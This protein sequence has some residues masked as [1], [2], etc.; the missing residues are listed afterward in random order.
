MAPVVAPAAP[1]VAVPSQPSAQPAVVRR[2]VTLL[3][4]SFAIGVLTLI[5]SLVTL[6][7]R[8]HSVGFAGRLL[9]FPIFWVVAIYFTMRRNNLGRIAVILL[10]AYAAFNLLFR[11]RLLVLSA[12]PGAI[13]SLV[14]LALRV[15]AVYLLLLPE[16]NAWFTGQNRG[17]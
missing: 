8:L 15:Y 14:E 6:I 7:G 10:V 17:T 1:M 4:V 11:F 3:W 13:V 16:S 9:L 2:A 5:V 12:N